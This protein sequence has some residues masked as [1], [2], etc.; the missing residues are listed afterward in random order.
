MP[1]TWA[2]DAP[3]HR[4][5][6][7]LVDAYTIEQWREAML[8]ILSDRSLRPRFTLLVDR[9]RASPPD[10]PFVDAMAKFFKTH[11]RRLS[12]VRAAVLVSSPEGAAMVEL[13][14]TLGMLRVPGLDIRAFH[15]SLAAEQWLE[16]SV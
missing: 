11:A 2:V 3:A 5:V 8:M 15:D 7:T 9:R 1:V 4:A 13:S 12:H 14:A 16:A 10:I 6:L